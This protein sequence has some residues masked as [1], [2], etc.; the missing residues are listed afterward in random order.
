MKGT[1]QFREWA[2]QKLQLDP[3]PKLPDLVPNLR[4]TFRNL[5]SERLTVCS[6]QITHSQRNM[7]E[8]SYCHNRGHSILDCRRLRVHQVARDERAPR[9]ATTDGRGRGRGRGRSRGRGRNAQAFLA[10]AVAGNV[11]R[12]DTW[13]ADTCATQH[14][15]NDRSYF[16]TFTPTTERCHFA[17][18]AVNVQV[19]GK[20][21]VVLRTPDGT[22]Q[23]RKDVLYVPSFSVNLLPLSSHA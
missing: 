8:C 21:T 19:A 2:V 10:V 16:Q 15:V 23:P 9:A 14:M 20:G 1:D 13:L 17:D 12:R 18:F 7:Q 5:F 4:T 6:L 22:L 11:S 3:V